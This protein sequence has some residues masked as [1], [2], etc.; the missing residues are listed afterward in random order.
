ML[1]CTVS[2]WWVSRR[3]WPPSPPCRRTWRSAGP[4]SSQTLTPHSACLPSARAPSY[5]TSWTTNLSNFLYYFQ[6]GNYKKI[7]WW[8]WVS[9]LTRSFYVMFLHILLIMTSTLVLLSKIPILRA[10]FRI[11]SDSRLFVAAMH[12]YYL[13]WQMPKVWHQNRYLVHAQGFRPFFVA[14]VLIP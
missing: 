9:D 1:R 5:R 6:R 4:A 13:R 8:T 14:P 2:W 11:P 12:P 10:V 3:W 7:Q